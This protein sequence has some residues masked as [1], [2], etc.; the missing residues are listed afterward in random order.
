M[1]QIDHLAVETYGIQLIQMMENA[2]RGL[3]KLTKMMLENSL[4]K[5]HLAVV[6][7]KGNNGGGGLVAA[8]HLYNW[9][10]KVT[11][12]LP[13]EPLSGVPEI[14]RKIIEKLPI[15][16]K[17]GK[18]ALQEIS[19][20]KYQIILDAMIGYGL[21]ANLK[22]WIASMI[23]KINTL[24]TTVLALD[25]PSGL[26][27]STGEIRDPC[28]RASA[29]MTLALPKRGLLRKEAR[30]TVGCLYLCDIG[31]PHILYKEIGLQVDPI[32]IE[33][34]IIK[35]ENIQEII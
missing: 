2:G 27:A 31:I 26:D 11:L 5:K 19:S 8:R 35:L 6:A 21:K 10:A 3:A 32:F 16:R 14:Q 33:D 9:G 7:G 1:K 4:L 24:D 25:L 29:T 17:I 23:K 34:N 28:I 22:G 20:S 12:M 13:Q 30:E 18:N 15:E